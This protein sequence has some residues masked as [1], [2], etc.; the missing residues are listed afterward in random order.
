MLR[1]SQQ[2]TPELLYLLHGDPDDFREALAGLRPADVAEAL[3]ELRPDLAA[4]VMAALP[5]EISVQ[6]FDEPEL[7]NHRCAIVQHMDQQAV[8]PLRVARSLRGHVR[9]DPRAPDARPPAAP[10]SSSAATCASV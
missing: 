7:A 9:N 1:A 3:R 2:S 4:K 10:D 5:F 6:V 8:G